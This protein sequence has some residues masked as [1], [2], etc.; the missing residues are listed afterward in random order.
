M[1]PY[2][3]VQGLGLNL[4]FEP[5]RPAVPPLNALGSPIYIPR[6]FHIMPVQVRSD[7]GI[8]SPFSFEPGDNFL[9][10]TD[11]CFLSEKVCYSLHLYGIY[12]LCGPVKKAVEL[13][14]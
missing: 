9:G 4:S 12:G 1:P 14:L 3:D 11:Y 5:L 8:C 6:V 2:I 7:E 13:F 10:A